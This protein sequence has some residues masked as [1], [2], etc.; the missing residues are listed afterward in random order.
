VTDRTT[1]SFDGWTLRTATGE[2]SRDGK[3]QR[4]TQQPLRILVEL[5]EHAGDVVTRE[6]LVELLWPKGV[7]DF[8]NGLNVAVRKVRL[9]LGDDTDTPRY[10]ETLPRVGYRFVGNVEAA[11]AHEAAGGVGAAPP[12]HVIAHA[13]PRRWALWVVALLAAVLL[14]ALGSWILVRAPARDAAPAVGVASNDPLVARKTTSVRAY[15]LYLQGIYNRSRRDADGFHLAV[16]NFEAAIREDPEYAP[17]WAGLSD[18]LVG[19]IIG[20]HVPTRAGFMRAR[21]ASLRAVELDG[22][23]AE[24]HTALGQIYMFFDRDYAKAE[25]EYAKARAANERYGRLWHHLGILRVFQGRPL[26]AL[27]AMRRAREVEPMT[28]LFS[29]NYGHVLYFSRRFDESIAHERE[30]LQAQPRLDQARSVLIR[31]LVAKGE[32]DEAQRELALRVAEV[33][34]L[35]DAGLV[36]AHLGQSEKTRAEIARIG[37]FSAQGFGVGYELAVLYAALGDV[38]GGCKALDLAWRDAS[39]FLGWMRLDPRMDPLRAQPCFV[40]IERRLGAGVALGSGR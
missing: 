6:R 23:I 2:L 9:A 33:P 31:A 1:Y 7:V 40:E 25:T 36:Y 14:V 12:P 22:G 10:I 18:A 38:D 15:E 8:D 26:E 32:A 39:P 13:R 5:L 4:L 28:L 20:Q 16:D 37:K 17:A 34:N 24:S 35:S 27:A 19:G 3:T 21:T 11:V 29:S 30:L